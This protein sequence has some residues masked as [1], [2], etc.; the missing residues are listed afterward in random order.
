MPLDAVKYW[1]YN[2]AKLQSKLPKARENA[3]NQV[4]IGLSF[5]SDG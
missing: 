2:N 5:V 3:G 1:Y 4:V